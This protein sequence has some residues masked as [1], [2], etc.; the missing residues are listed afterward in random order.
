VFSNAPPLPAAWLPDT[1]VRVR[2][3]L[4]LC[5][6]RP[7]PSRALRLSRIAQSVNVADEYVCA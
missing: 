3:G 4:A 7:P 6:Y 2:L 5:A 1:C